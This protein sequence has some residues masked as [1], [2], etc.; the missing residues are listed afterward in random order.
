IDGS[1]LIPTNTLK[2]AGIGFL[3]ATIAGLECTQHVPGLTQRACNGFFLVLGNFRQ[4]AYQ[5]TEI[6]ELRLLA[7]SL[8]ADCREEDHQG[9]VRSSQPRLL[10]GGSGFLATRP[11]VSPGD[12]MRYHRPLPPGAMT[13]RTLYCHDDGRRTRVSLGCNRLFIRF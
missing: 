3:G 7:T 4:A 9:Q 13:R 2:R 8:K 10:D 5:K 11:S 1:P 12:L 6:R